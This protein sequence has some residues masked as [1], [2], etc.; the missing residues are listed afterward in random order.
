VQNVWQKIYDDKNDDDKEVVEVEE[1]EK[2]EDEN[3]DDKE[4][5]QDK[6]QKEDCYNDYSYTNESGNVLGYSLYYC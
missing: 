3:D 2:K 5:D 4:Q 6:D 1:E